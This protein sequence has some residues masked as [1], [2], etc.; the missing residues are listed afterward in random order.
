M[1]SR[2]RHGLLASAIL[3]VMLLGVSARNGGALQLLF[4]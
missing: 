4:G 2:S 1:P 3:T